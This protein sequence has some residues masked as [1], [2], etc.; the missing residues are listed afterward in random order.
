MDVL[1]EKQKKQAKKTF[2]TRYAFPALPEATPTS[3]PAYDGFV[4]MATQKR[5]E[6]SRYR[7]RFHNQKNNKFKDHLRREF[8]HVAASCSSLAS[9]AVDES[10]FK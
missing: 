2:S 5:V 9:L 10:I 4:G 6:K 7:V 8:E 3:T 1:G